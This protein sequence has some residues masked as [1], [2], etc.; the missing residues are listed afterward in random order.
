MIFLFGHYTGSTRC[1]QRAI[2]TL[3]N[4]EKM[5]RQH[6]P[7]TLVLPANVRMLPSYRALIDNN[8]PKVNYRFTIQDAS[9]LS[10]VYI[11]HGLYSEVD[12]V[13]TIRHCRLQFKGLVEMSSQEAFKYLI[14][15]NRQKVT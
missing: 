13:N 15:E 14:A 11:Y 10:K 9:D 8:L 3:Q 7:K 6:T 2:A 12:W 1:T 5:L 4:V